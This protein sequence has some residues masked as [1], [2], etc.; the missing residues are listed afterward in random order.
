MISKKVIFILIISSIFSCSSFKRVSD[1]Y[2]DG[3]SDNIG[4]C[5]N[6]SGYSW[7]KGYPLISEMD[8]KNDALQGM[9]LLYNVNKV[10][11]NVDSIYK[12]NQEYFENLKGFIA[13]DSENYTIGLTSVS[14]GFLEKSEDIDISIKRVKF[15][16]QYLVDSLHVNPKSI[17]ISGM[18]AHPRTYRSEKIK[19]YS[20][21]TQ[22]ILLKNGY[23]YMFNLGI[24]N[25][26]DN[27]G[28]LN[29]EDDCPEIHGLKENNGCPEPNDEEIIP[30]NSK[31]PRIYF[32]M[33]EI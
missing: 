6:Y 23:T 12:S 5:T 33:N 10:E 4:F 16:K 2:K 13:H 30:F 3:V 26:S 25:D 9:F 8:F 7:N 29:S 31:Y 17:Q 22:I 19:D 18:D 1:I 15:I 27:D 21:N 24:F 28:N 20:R 14:S 32:K 11:I